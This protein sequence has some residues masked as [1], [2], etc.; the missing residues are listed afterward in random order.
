MNRVFAPVD[1]YTVDPRLAFMKDCTRCK[2][3]PHANE[4]CKQVVMPVGSLDA[5]I[6]VILENPGF[7]ENETGFTLS[8][9]SYPPLVGAMVKHYG[10]DELKDMLRT[11]I[12]LCIPKGKTKPTKLQMRQCRY[13]LD[14]IIDNMPNLKLIIPVGRIALQA[15][16]GDDAVLSLRVGRPGRREYIY[17][18]GL[19]SRRSF[20]TLPLIHPAH[21]LRI[22]NERGRIRAAMEYDSNLH[23]LRDFYDNIDHIEDYVAPYKYHICWTVEENLYWANFITTNKDIQHIVIDFET[24]EIVAPGYG[25][26]ICMAVAF[27]LDG[28]IHAVVFVFKQCVETEIREVKRKKSKV[29]FEHKWKLIPWFEKRPTLEREVMEM[30]KPKMQGDDNS[31]FLSAWNAGF[32]SIT[33]LMNWGFRITPRREQLPDVWTPTTIDAP[34]RDI[35]LSYRFLNSDLRSLSLKTVLSASMPLISESKDL[36][37]SA[38]EYLYNKSVVNETG[39]MLMAVKPPSDFSN[40]DFQ[41]YGKI[42]NEWLAECDKVKEENK[43]LTAK[44]KKNKQNSYA[45][46]LEEK[47]KKKKLTVPKV[48][49]PSCPLSDKPLRYIEQNWCPNLNDTRA[50]VLFE[51][52]AF[53]S[54]VEL[55]LWKRAQNMFLNEEVISIGAPFSEE[56]FI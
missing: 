8:G 22:E 28:E 26:I 56:I 25:I 7:W 41:H 20:Y 33:S 6:L 39:Y 36:I 21:D 2:L 3:G 35:M 34:P 47:P 48:K 54:C 43:R 29:V 4:D 13:N 24:S 23:F 42:Y 16:E 27:E 5:E 50:K 18:N 46:S 19:S 30:F 51:R 55:D 15:V 9:P 37:E 45:E 31:F 49:L 52:A 10:F 1:Q 12:N 32:D 14:F 11:N 44:A 40:E 38:I 53:D 17:A